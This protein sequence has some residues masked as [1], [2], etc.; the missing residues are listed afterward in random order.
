MN[1]LSVLSGPTPFLAVVFVLVATGKIR[2]ISKEERQL[3]KRISRAKDQLRNSP[4]SL[5]AEA[6]RLEQMV[7]REGRIQ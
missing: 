7:Q 6:E 4:E 1:W 3:R 5:R 2:V